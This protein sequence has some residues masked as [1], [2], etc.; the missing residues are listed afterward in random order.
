MA[1]MADGGK[2]RAREETPSCLSLSKDLLGGCPNNFLNNAS[3]H[4]A[5]SRVA[6]GATLNFL[7]Q[8]LLILL[9]L[10]SSQ[11]INSI[12]YR[13]ALSSNLENDS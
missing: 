8:K 3:H 10:L 1:L 4:E 11:S 5:N 2:C 9:L 6:E 12:A 7:K 13:L